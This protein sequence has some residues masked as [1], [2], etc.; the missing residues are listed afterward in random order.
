MRVRIVTTKGDWSCSTTGKGYFVSILIPELKKLGVEVVTEA[1]IPCD[2]DM[3]IGKWVYEPKYCKKKIL[4]LGPPHFD[5]AQKYKKLNKRKINAVKQADGVIYQSAWSKIMC[6]K[7]LKKPDC[8][9]AVIHNG[10]NKFDEKYCQEPHCEKNFVAA[11]RKW[12]PQ[13]RIEDIVEAFLISGIHDYQLY[14]LGDCKNK[15]YGKR[16]ISGPV[17]HDDLIEIM[18]SARAVIH[19]VYLDACPN[20]VAEAINQKTPV[21]CTNQ[22]GTWEMVVNHTPELIVQDKEY[23]FK[24]IDLSRPPKADVNAIAS[25]MRKVAEYDGKYPVKNNEMH[26]IEN[27]AARYLSFFEK[28]LNG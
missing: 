11:A 25:A 14:I 13:K 17:D 8:I 18:F 21:I 23:D 22:G 19:C 9:T 26:N 2:I 7:F 1:D 28:V 4:R 12:L 6:D 24:P 16:V 27:I 10:A 3:G 20:V 15:Y 5:K